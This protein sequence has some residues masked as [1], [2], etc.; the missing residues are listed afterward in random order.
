LR[1]VGSSFV[2]RSSDPRLTLEQWLAATDGAASAD[3]LARACRL[4]DARATD[5]GAV[6]SKRFPA[7]RSTL[8]LI[9]ELGVG[10]EALAGC[11]LHALV[12]SGSPLA[13]SDLAEFPA[14]V[15]N[16]VEGQ[17]AAERVWSIYASRGNT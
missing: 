12:E 16:L 8:D 17:Q 14:E 11:V 1:A 10:S 4:A 3:V 6:W 2:K 9:R 5:I 13:D 15:R 7:L